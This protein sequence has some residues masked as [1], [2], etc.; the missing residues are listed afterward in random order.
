MSPSGWHTK[1]YSGSTP[2][3]LTRGRVRT[4]F[5]CTRTRRPAHEEGDGGA[6]EVDEVG[7][8]ADEKGRR[9]L[10]VIIGDAMWPW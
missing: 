1:R 8:P 5:H 7:A 2:M 3:S 4:S 6:G 9:T 10:Q